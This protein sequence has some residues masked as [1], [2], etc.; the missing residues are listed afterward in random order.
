VTEPSITNCSLTV[1]SIFAGQAMPIS[2]AMPGS[3]TWSQL[4]MTSLLLI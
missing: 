4:K 1:S 3:I 2:A